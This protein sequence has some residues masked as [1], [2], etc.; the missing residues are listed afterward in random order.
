[1]RITRLRLRDLKV[2]RELDLELAS[3]I[4]VVRGP[5][6]AGKT[7]LQR[8]LELAL[9]RKVTASGAEIDALRSW[10]ADDE[11]RPWIAMDFVQED[12]DGNA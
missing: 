6:E 7:T 4:T 3:G 9:F 1:M 8:A 11:G 2:H 12:P 10:G 5:N